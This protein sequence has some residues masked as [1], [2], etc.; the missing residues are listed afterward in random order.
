MVRLLRFAD[1][2]VVADTR[3]GAY[4]PSLGNRHRPAVACEGG[5]FNANRAREL[6][7]AIVAYKDALRR[8]QRAPLTLGGVPVEVHRPDSGNGRG[9][10]RVECCATTFRN[11]Q[12][13]TIIE[14]VLQLAHYCLS[15]LGARLF[16]SPKLHAT[17]TRRGFDR[18]RHWR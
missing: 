9:S 10:Y 11:E 6:S 8:L 5:A 12:H 13:G 1:N 18:I 17:V 2:L 14:A 3:P 15:L 7:R 16:R 4:N